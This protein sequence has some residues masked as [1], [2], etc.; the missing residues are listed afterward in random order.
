MASWNGIGYKRFNVREA[1]CRLNIV[2]KK[3]E[4]FSIFYEKLAAEYNNAIFN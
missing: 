2:S 3:M 4:D 1:Q